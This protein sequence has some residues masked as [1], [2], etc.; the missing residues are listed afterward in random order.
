[1]GSSRK[2]TSGRWSSAAASSHFIRSPSESW[3]VGL[4]HERRRGR[5]ARSS[6]ASV[7]L[8]LRARDVVDGAVQLERL[9]RRQVP[10]ELL[11]LPHHQRDA[12]QERGLALLRRVAGDLHV[13]RRGVKQPDEH[14]E[15]RRLAR[16]VGA[17]EADAL[18]RFDD[19]REI[20]DGVHRLVFAM[21]QR[22]QGV[23]EAR[24]ATVHAVVLVQLL[25]PDAAHLLV[26]RHPRSLVGPSPLRAHPKHAAGEPRFS[27]FEDWLGG[28]G[29]V[30]TAPDYHDPAGTPFGVPTSPRLPVLFPK[31][32]RET[33]R[34]GVMNDRLQ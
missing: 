5:A 34:W 32:N 33:P 17:E 21:N 15:R 29:R 11:L 2:S 14:L 16:A 12:F 26:H 3:R 9:R 27:S 18:A 22:T 4:L 23:R 6:S 10:E 24:L 30:P 19:E 28:G 13:A 8:E 31:P 20:V 7:S 25:Y 1:M